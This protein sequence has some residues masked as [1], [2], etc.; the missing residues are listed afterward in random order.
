MTRPSLTDWRPGRSGSHRLTPRAGLPK[1][2]RS[3]RPRAALL[4]A[5]ALATA[6]PPP[7][8]A[9]LAAASL[10]PVPLVAAP[11]PP[12]HP[13]PIAPADSANVTQVSSGRR[14][15]SSTSRSAWRRGFAGRL[16]SLPGRQRNR[17]LPSDVNRPNRAKSAAP[18]GA[19][20]APTSPR[21]RLSQ[22]PATSFKAAAT[23]ARK[24]G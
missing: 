8:V 15:L 3:K 18:R 16:K 13:A 7:A 21:E 1:A 12:P 5:R 19:D 20:A 24:E 2:P 9:P 14:L 17:A 23:R 4:A 22:R 11:P 10:V 6:A